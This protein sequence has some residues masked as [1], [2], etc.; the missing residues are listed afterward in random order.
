MAIPVI[1]RLANTAPGLEIWLDSSPLVYR[2]WMQK[3]LVSAPRENKQELEKQLLNL[4]D[5]DDVC[6]SIVKGVTTNPKLSLIAIQE[7]P[8]KWKGW[9]E[10]YLKSHDTRD[11]E[12]V[13]WQLYKEI[14][15]NGAEMLMPLFESSGYRY[16]FLSGQLDPRNLFNQEIMLEQA[17]ELVELSPNIMVKVPGSHEGMTVLRKLTASGISTNCTLCYTVP[18]YI[19]A[20][21]AVQ[22]GSEEARAKGVDLT[23][24]RSVITAMNAR[25]ENASIFNEQA[26]KEGIQLTAEHKILASSAIFKR[27]YR[28]FR[29][30]AYPSK[31]LIC[32]VRTG[33]V[34]NG[35]RRIWHL[36]ETAG[37]DAVFTLPIVF[38]SELYTDYFDSPEIQFTPAIWRDIPESYWNDLIRIPYFV[39]SFE[40][41]GIASPDFNDIMALQ[42]THKEFSGATEE[43]VDFV[44]KMIAAIEI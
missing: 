32:S 40:E 5:P 15:R 35:R 39:Q 9:I 22:A 38:Y 19:A 6:N 44:R 34:V 31:M 16:G 20:A 2:S 41:D 18:Q 29:A 8:N 27:A 28:L 4:F 13:F 30:R 1:E 36:E 33:P 11:V 37:A 7:D 23:R 17:H 3:M 24:W 21:N 12:H 42:N 43:M 26:E 10:G 25:W 14:V